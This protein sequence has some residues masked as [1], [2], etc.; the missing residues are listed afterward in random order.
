MAVSNVST[1]NNKTIWKQSNLS[2]TI[3]Y[4]IYLAVNETAGVIEIV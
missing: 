2:F 3:S 4:V 1:V